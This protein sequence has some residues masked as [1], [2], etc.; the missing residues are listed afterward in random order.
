MEPH[1]F[2]PRLV[3]G[4]TLRRAAWDGQVPIAFVL[5]ETDVTALRPPDPVYVSA[6]LRIRS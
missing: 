3:D 5:A 6:Y 2:H 4:N 1:E